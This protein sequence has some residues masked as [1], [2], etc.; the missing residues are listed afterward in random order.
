MRYPGSLD[1]LDFGETH[2]DHGVLL[3]EVGGSKPA[4]PVRLP[5]PATLFHTIDLAD[6]EADLPGLVDKY[7]DHETA[8]V[9]VTVG[10]PTGD[11]SGDEIARQLR[12]LFPRL[13]D[14]KWADAG[15]ADDGAPSR[16]S[17]RAGFQTTVREWLTERL[18]ADPD[19]DAVLALAETF[20][21]A[22]AES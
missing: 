6:P 17:P 16:F 13:Y 19:R 15:P 11:L 2:D 1:R 9:R 3:V 21:T 4:E 20:L 7:P 5:I 10:R 22:E 18:A 14:L 12:K 8:I